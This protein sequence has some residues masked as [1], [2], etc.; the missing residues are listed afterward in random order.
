MKKK[1]LIF[2]EKNEWLQRVTW[3]DSFPKFIKKPQ[4]M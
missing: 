4:N 2:K 3:N 1:D